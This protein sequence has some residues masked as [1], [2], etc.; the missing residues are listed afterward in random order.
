MLLAVGNWGLGGAGCDGVEALVAIV[1]CVF[2]LLCS[3]IAR[4]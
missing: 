1:N 2:W 4:R 3:P